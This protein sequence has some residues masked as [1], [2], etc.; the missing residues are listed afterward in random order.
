M[1]PVLGQR[2]KDGKWVVGSAFVHWLGDIYTV[3]IGGLI[4]LPQ[5]GALRA[6]QNIMAPLHQTLSGLGLVL[7]PWLSG[8]KAS[9]GD[10]AVG[11]AVNKVVLVNSV[12]AIG[13]G[14]LL[15]L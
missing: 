11:L 13:Y 3:L 12:L 4:G 9:R 7:Q 10:R 2:W 1:G 14:E 6:F 8:Q 5:A 15:L